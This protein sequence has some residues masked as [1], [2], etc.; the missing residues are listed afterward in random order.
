MLLDVTRGG[1]EEVFAWDHGDRVGHEQRVD[2]TLIRPT[3]YIE[4]STTAMLRQ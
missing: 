2:G 3:W 1:G 4:T